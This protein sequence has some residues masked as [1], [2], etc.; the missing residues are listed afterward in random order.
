MNGLRP[1]NKKK[2]KQKRHSATISMQEGHSHKQMISVKD[3]MDCILCNM[4]VRSWALKHP[5]SVFN[6][7]RFPLVLR[8]LATFIRSKPMETAHILALL[9]NINTFFTHLS[10][11]MHVTCQINVNAFCICISAY[12]YQSIELWN[13]SFEAIIL[14]LCH[15]FPDYASL[16]LCQFYFFRPMNNVENFSPACKH[17]KQKA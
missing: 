13:S 10:C 12:I 3:E 7:R 6:F 2:K 11:T 9:T 14:M 4:H 16:C 1:A 17:S 8:S 5:T 15:C